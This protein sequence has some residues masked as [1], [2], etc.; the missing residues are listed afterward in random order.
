MLC[1][2]LCCLGKIVSGEGFW[3]D[4]FW[5]WRVGLLIIEV[6]SVV[7]DKKCVL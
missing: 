6:E 3:N 1:Y 2:I 5:D 4:G 7:N